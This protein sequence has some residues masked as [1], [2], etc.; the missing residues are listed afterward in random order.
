MPIFIKMGNDD[1]PPTYEK[2]LLDQK[3][4]TCRSKLNKSTLLTINKVVVGIK[5][6][7]RGKNG[8]K[9]KVRHKELNSGVHP[10]YLC[11]LMKDVNTSDGSKY[12]SFAIVNTKSIRNKAEEFTVHIIEDSIDLTFICETWFKDDDTDIT[13]FLESSG[14]KFY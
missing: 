13:N 5:K 7:F 2:Q 3:G 4:F 14:F 10:Q 6:N 1:L 11:S 9:R 8:K 12:I